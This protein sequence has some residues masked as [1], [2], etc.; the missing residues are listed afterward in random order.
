MSTIRPQDQCVLRRENKLALLLPQ[1]KYAGANKNKFV[2]CDTQL[3]M[4]ASS[5]RYKKSSIGW[6]QSS[7]RADS[8]LS[9]PTFCFG[10]H[11]KSRK[12]SAF[13]RSSL[14]VNLPDLQ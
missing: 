14:V 12:R 13:L 4:R 9:R 8:Y 2:S 3:R 11:G 1:A 7:S 6:A 5:R 10:G